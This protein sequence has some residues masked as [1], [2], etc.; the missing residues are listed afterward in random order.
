MTDPEREKRSQRIFYA[1]ILSLILGY[2]A[3]KYRHISLALDAYQGQPLPV[4]TTR[5]AK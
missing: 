1:L 5:A 4:D 2:A 3:V